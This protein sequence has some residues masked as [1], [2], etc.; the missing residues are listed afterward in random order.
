MWHNTE[1]GLATGFNVKDPNIINGI[2]RQAQKF[3]EEVNSTTWNAL[4]LSLQEGIRDGES[5]DKIAG[6]VE[7]VMGDRIKSSSQA[8]AR[9]EVNRAVAFGTIEGWKQSG[10]VNQVKWIAALDDRTRPTHVEAH[11]QTVDIGEDFTVGGCTGPG[12]GML[13]CAREVVNCR[14]SVIAVL[15]VP[16]PVLPTKGE[17]E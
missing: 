14:C 12:P 16:E 4:K 17:T 10:V 15:D 7:S 5:I 6:R 9:T 2:E 11:G 3:A 8:I 1:V 13:D